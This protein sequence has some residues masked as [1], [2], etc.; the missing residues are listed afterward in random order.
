M[1]G[2][3]VQAL[4]QQREFGRISIGDLARKVGCGEVNFRPH[5]AEM[6]YAAKRIDI[7]LDIDRSA[8]REVHSRRT[9]KG[10][11]QMPQQGNGNGNGAVADLVASG[12]F[13]SKQRIS[14]CADFA[15]R[16]SDRQADTV[17]EMKILLK[18][19]NRGPDIFAMHKDFA[20]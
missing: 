9:P 20:K 11:N 3:R 4:G 2:H 17:M 19:G 8:P 16:R 6:R 7:R 14:N 13:S 1:I 18:I 10:A 15:V 12:R 5:G